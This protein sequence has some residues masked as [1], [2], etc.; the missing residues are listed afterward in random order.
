ME[1]NTLIIIVTGGDGFI[2]SNLIIHML[3]CLKKSKDVRS[4]IIRVSEIEL[5]Y[6][7]PEIYQLEE[8][9]YKK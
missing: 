5:K 8:Y 3:S 4:D 6:N 7:N 9:K 2:G 1:V